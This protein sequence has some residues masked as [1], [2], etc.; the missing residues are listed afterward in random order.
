MWIRGFVMGGLR[1]SVPCLVGSVSI[2]ALPH[3]PL[4]TTSPGAGAE[5]ITRIA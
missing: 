4:S 5:A 2:A 1:L 3:E